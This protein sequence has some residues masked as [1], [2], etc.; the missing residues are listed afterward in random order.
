VLF[1]HESPKSGRIGIATNRDFGCSIAVK[2]KEADAS[3][4]E[5]EE[6]VVVGVY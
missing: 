5:T 3:C 4:S 1:S 2:G 6:L